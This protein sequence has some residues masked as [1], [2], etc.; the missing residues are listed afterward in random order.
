MLQMNAHKFA[1]MN[2]IK[3]LWA[4]LIK[5]WSSLHIQIEDHG[6]SIG[7]HSLDHCPRVHMVAHA[8]LGLFCYPKFIFNYL[9]IRVYANCEV[10]RFDYFVNS[11][12]F[13][14]IY[15]VWVYA[16][17]EVLEFDYFVIPS[18]FLI[19]VVLFIPLNLIFWTSSNFCTIFID[20]YSLICS[21]IKSQ[22]LLLCNNLLNFN[23]KN[24]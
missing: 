22:S 16:S 6:W 23:Y 24:F 4:S 5:I 1:Y 11:S 10:L 14:I 18:S 12:W 19:R 2:I 17:Y 3:L 21:Y 9:Q 20:L 8:S 13:S 15:E 7:G